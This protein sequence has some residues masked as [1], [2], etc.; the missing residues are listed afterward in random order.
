M[1][2]NSK[3]PKAKDKNYICNPKTGRWVLKSG[4]IGK[5]VKVKP[6]VKPTGKPVQ[7]PI[8]KHFQLVKPAGEFVQHPKLVKPVSPKPKIKTPIKSPNKSPPKIKSPYIK[9]PNCFKSSKIDMKP[10]QILFAQKFINSKIHGVVA[11]HGLGSGKTLTAITTS[12][13][14]LEKYPDDK[15]VVI[16]PASLIKNFQQEM[17]KWGVKNMDKYEFYTFDSFKNMPSN[18]KNSLL[19]IDEA[20][21]LRT[22]IKITDKD[23]KSIGKAKIKVANTSGGKKSKEKE[24]E[25]KSSGLKAAEIIHCAKNARRVLMLTGTP[26]VN[27]LYDLENLMA[28]SYGR[29]PLTPTKFKEQINNHIENYFKCRISFFTPAKEHFPSHKIYDIYFKMSPK[30]LETYNQIETTGLDSHFKWSSENL[31]MFYNGVRQASNSV[32]LEDTNSPKIDWII[33]KINKSEPKDKFVIFSH[34]IDAG[35]KLL[36][37]K[38]DKHH[39]KYRIISGSVS[40]TK[41]AEYVKEYNDGKIKVLFITKAGGE[42]LN[43]MET[44]SIMLMEPSWN[45]TTVKQVIGRAIRFKSHDKLPP[46]KQHVD[47]FKLYTIKPSEYP[48]RYQILNNKIKPKDMLSIDLYLKKMSLGK[49]NVIDKTLNYLKNLPTLETCK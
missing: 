21:N 6:S 42:G 33:Y 9:L 17:E 37:D 8:T 16:T 15:V 29:D 45:E 12:Q 43:L 34:F 28:M 48:V 25:K 20:H 47:V 1:N 5:D 31:N 24:K 35:S 41:R 7:Q 38:L 14:Y 11:V 22:K 46:E 18:C 40:K 4:S 19:I 10:H 36:S 39:I 2:C 3:S 23:K 27:T 49:Q 30:Y 44:T 13:C 26:A 32:F